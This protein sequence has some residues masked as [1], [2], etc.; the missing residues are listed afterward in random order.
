MPMGTP[1][2]RREPARAPYGTAA[3]AT[4]GTSSTEAPSPTMAMPSTEVPRVAAPVIGQQPPVVYGTAPADV[5][6]AVESS[7]VGPPPRKPVWPWVVAVLGLVLGGLVGWLMSR[8]D[9]DDAVMT[10]TEATTTTVTASSVPA[11][12]GIDEQLD[13]LLAQ[14]RA[15]GAYPGAS[16]FPQI[17]EIVEIDRVANA[18]SLQ[19]QVDLL[20]IA[21]EDSVA[22]IGELEE[23]VA[24]LEE[25][26]AEVTAERDELEAQ[27]ESGTITDTEFLARLQE[28][29][30]QLAALQDQLDTATTQATEAQAATQKAT[31][32]LRVAQADLQRANASLEALDPIAIESY[33]NTDIARLRADAASN[34]WVLVERQ[35]DGSAATPGLVTSQSPGAG[36]T[37]VR[38]GVVYVEF[39]GP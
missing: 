16:Q 30:D 8:S 5:P 36:A 13:A 19:N 1:A 34:G 17:D 24:T 29:E 18:E 4:A 14:T 32:D 37:V 33:V 28:K 35:V 23:Q 10:Q 11:D 6:V 26:L 3:G 20:S 31:D 39:E 27:A 38:G 15:T 2:D 22:K 12:A 9:D 21:Q 7:V 25:S